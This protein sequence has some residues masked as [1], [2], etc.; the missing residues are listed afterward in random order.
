MIPKS[1]YRFSEKIMRKQ[2]AGLRAPRKKR[3]RRA[4]RT[5]LHARL[6]GHVALEAQ[7]NGDLIVSFSG[8]SFGLGKLSPAATARAAELRDGLPFAAFSRDRPT[9][10]EL[11]ALVRLLAR[12]GLLEYVLRRG[13]DAADAIVIEPQM[14]DY[15]PRSA[16]LRDADVLALSRFAYLRRRGTEMVLES[17][18]AGALFRIGDPQIAAALA[19]LA[20]PRSLRWLRRESGAAVE[21]LG[22]LLDCDVIFKVDAGHSGL[23]PEEGDASL[24]LWDFHDLLFH[25]RSSEGRHANPIGGV[26]SYAHVTPPL[27]AIR[28]GWSGKTIDLR[29]VSDAEPPASPTAK[30]MRARH[31]VRS[32]DPQRPVTLAELARFLDASARVTATWQVEADEGGPPVTYARRPYPSAGASYEL[33]LYLA[34]DNCAGLAKGFYHYDAGAHV[35]VPIEVRAPDMEALLTGAALAMDAPAVPQVLIAI[36]ARFA[37]VS[38]KYSTL[39]YGLMLKDAGV[40][41]QTL[42]LTAADMGLGGCAIGSVNIDLFARMT[43]LDFHVEGPVGQFAL[44]RPAARLGQAPQQTPTS[45]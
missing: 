45:S 25:A 27:P 4:A 30:L 19:S 12:R 26:Y 32:F 38:W 43:G 13:D 21:L 44:G 8:F 40:L 9:D 41:T 35:L 22:L 15:W 37:R 18:R 29:A 20:A 2:K 39:A 31:S 23:R 24:V 7:A 1:G 3:G 6:A 10:K 14:A 16:P 28:P 11:D 17:P 33:E 5:A 34:V 36:A 42:Y